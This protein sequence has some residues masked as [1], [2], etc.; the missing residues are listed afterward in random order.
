MNEY[1]ISGIENI[2]R[3]VAVMDGELLVCKAKG[4]LSAY[5]PGGHIEFGESGREALVREIREELGVEAETGR[6][7]GAVE[8][9][10]LQNG[11]THAEINLVYELVFKE[12][13][14]AEAREDWLE[15]E[16][17]KLDRLGEI[18]LLPAEFGVLAENPSAT[19][20]V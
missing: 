20:S 7:L 2:A 10:F 15:F 13:P 16:W 17:V 18:N 19:F 6:F 1:E 5:L 4:G 3:G 12:K 11:R 9:K 14:A 8:N